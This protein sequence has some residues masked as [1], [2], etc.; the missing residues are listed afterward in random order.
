MFI[1]KKKSEEKKTPFFDYSAEEKKKVLEH[2]LREA[3]RMQNELIKK[4][5]LAYTSSK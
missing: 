1:F 5:N 4:Y 2:S 3:I